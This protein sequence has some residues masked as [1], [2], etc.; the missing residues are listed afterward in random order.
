MYSLLTTV[1]ACLVASCLGIPGEETESPWIDI[2][3][4]DSCCF[5]VSFSVINGISETEL[6]VSRLD[7]FI[8]DADAVKEL[9]DRRTYTFLP[10]SVRFYGKDGDKTV[11]AIA[12]SPR[13]FNDE[14]LSRYDSIELVSFS[15]EEDS[16]HSPLMGGQCAVAPGAGTKL[17]LTPLLARIKLGEISNTMSGYIRLENP[18]VW[19][20]NMNAWAELLRTAG[21]RPS[22]TIEKPPPKPLPYDIGIFAQTPGT[23]LFC[24]PNDSSPDSGTPAT[25]FVLECEIGGATCSFRTP[26]PTIGRNTTTRIDVS[27]SGPDSFESKVY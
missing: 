7:L 18:R 22:Q 26:I 8:Y 9:L 16:P 6:P 12:N 27:V 2:T 24:Y 19:L 4:A 3:P 14:A 5:T 25:A 1:P 15:S 23:E 17:T 21:F 20:E 13:E 11:V 10:D